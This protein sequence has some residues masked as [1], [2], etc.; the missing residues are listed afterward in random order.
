MP[1]K[2][3]YIQYT[4]TA[5]IELVIYILYIRERL[6]LKILEDLIRAS[7]VSYKLAASSSR[8]WGDPLANLPTCNTTL[9]YLEFWLTLCTYIIYTLPS[10]ALLI[11]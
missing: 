8:C 3:I 6:K 1:I 2:Y 4:H 11:P 7:D 5:E 9:S 10:V